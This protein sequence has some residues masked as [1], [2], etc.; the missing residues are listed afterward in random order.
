MLDFIYFSKQIQIFAVVFLFFTASL[1]A[2]LQSTVTGDAINQGNNCF[3]ITP[4]ELNQ[5]GGAW[6]S[7]PIDFDEDFT[8]YYQNNF[9]TKDGNG[10]DGMA[11]VFKSTSTPE[12]GN[13]G[14]GMG[15]EGIINS[16]II[17]F[18]TFLNGVN[19]DPFF[20][21]LAILRDGNPLH[22]GATALTPPVQASAANPNIEDGV[23][24]EV[25]IVWTAT[26]Q[27][28][29]VYFDC[30]LRES[31]TAN[32]KADVFNGDDTVFFG[33][34]GSTGGLSNLHQVCFNSISFVDDL[35]LQD[36]SI[37][38]G[39]FI[40][41]DATVPSGTSYSWSPTTGVGSPNSPITII[42]PTVTT[43]YAVTI[44]DNCG[45]SST[46]NI[47]ITINDQNPV[48][49]P[50]PNYNIGDAIPPLPTTSNNGVTGTWS[51]EIDNTETTTYT[52]TPDSGQC[53]S[54]Q[55]LT[56]FINSV[57]TDGDGVPDNIDIDDD[58][59]GI[60]DIN[61]LAFESVASAVFDPAIQQ[62][63]FSNISL[64]AGSIYQLTPTSFTLPQS[65]VNGGPFNGQT[66]QEIVIYDSFNDL[67]SDFNGNT[68]D[69]NNAYNGTFAGVDIPFAN[70]QASDYIT[71]LTYIGLVDTNGNG[72]YD[73]G[74]DEIIEP[75]FAVNEI[76]SFEPS[77][78]GDFYIVYTD[79]FYSDNLGELS[80]DTNVSSNLDTD[81]DG[82]F[83]RLD[84]DSDN[85]GIPDNVEAQTTLGYIP[86]SG[87]EAS[88]TDIDGD[89]LDDIYDQD[90][91][92]SSTETSIGLIPVNTDG[93]DNPDFTDEDSDN[94]GFPDIE[95]NGLADA[96]SIPFAD[97]DGD[98]LDNV[99]D[100]FNGFDVNNNIDNPETDLPDCNNNI[101][102][103]GDVDFREDLVLPS[104]LSI[105]PICEGGILEEL[106]VISTNGVSGT[107]SPA[108]NNTQTTTYTFTPD[109]VSCALETTL[110]IIVN[111]AITPIFDELPSICE[112]DNISPLPT[113]SNNGISGVW[114]P[115]LD[116]T[117][118]TTYTFT[119]NEDE[120]AITSTLVLTVNE[121][122][123]PIFDDIQPVCVGENI[124]PLPTTSNNGINGV[125]SPEL[126][127]TQ[128]TT[129]TFTPNEDECATSTT[130]EIEVN[131]VLSPVFNNIPAYCL[132]DNTPPLPIT[133]DNGINGTWSPALD[134][135]QTTFYTFT[136][137]EDECAEVITFEVDISEPEIVNPPQNLV[138]CGDFTGTQTFD[139]T[140]NDDATL[141][142]LTSTTFTYHNTLADALSG[143]NVILNPINYIP[144]D[145]QETIFIRIE[146]DTNASCF[147]TTS[148]SIERFD[149][150]ALTGN[151]LELCDDGSG[152]ETAIFDLT[153]NNSAILG[154]NQTT[155]SHNI[156]YHESPADADIGD[157]LIANPDVYQNLTSPQIIW[158]RVENQDN[159]DC[160]EVS[161]FQLLVT[162]S[163]P[164][165]TNISP[166]IACDDDNDGFFN[167]F[168]LTSKDNEI[169]FGNTDVSISYH[170][171]P[172]DAVNAVGALS[173]P[174]ANVVENTQTIYF[175]AVDTNN[176]CE[177]FG[178]FELQI[179]DSPL[180]IPITE[181]LV[182]CDEDNDGF[183][184]FDLT[185]VETEAL[186]NLDPL[187]LEITYHLSLADAQAGV[188]P[189]SEPDNYL[190]TNPTETIWIRVL[191]ISNPNGC[192]DVE[193]FDIIVEPTP[194]I[195]N[196]E[197]LAICDDEE[198]GDLS[199]EI[200]TFDLNDKIQEITQGNN[201]Y[202]VEFFESQ[203]D[204]DNNNPIAPIDSYVNIA[205]PQTLEIRVTSSTNACESFTTLTLVV[206]PVPSMAPE[207]DPIEI[208]DPDNDGFG[209]F[210]LDLAIVDILNNEPDVTITFH[211]TL[212]D[213]E[214]GVN[215][216]DTSQP[217]GSNNTNQQTLYVRAENTGPNGND[218]TGCF[219]TRPIDLIVVPSPEIDNLEDLTR[220][221]DE[222]PNGFASFDLTLNQDLALGNQNPDDVNITYHETQND[223]ELGIN[224]IA[225]PSNYT[226]ITNPQIIYVRI[227]DLTTGCY[228]LF[229]TTDDIN[230]TFT[231][232]VEPLPVVN[233]PAVLQVCDDD[234]N[235]D[236]FPQT[237]FDLTSTET[238]V[239]GVV[240]VPANLEYSYYESQEDFDNDNPIADP[241]AYVNIAQPQSILIKV[242]DTATENECFDATA[243][244]ISVLPLPSPSET[245]P[246]VLRLEAC[247]DEGNDG[248]AESPFDLTESGVLIAGSENVDLSF[249]L[250][251]DGAM[252]EDTDELIAD[253]TAYVNDP[254]LNLVDED[255]NP[256]STQVIYVR[257]DNATFGNFCFVVVPMEIVV[258]PAPVINPAGD[259]FAYTLCEDDSANPGQAMLFSTD[260]ITGNLWDITNGSADV[261]IP[262]LDPDAVPVQNIENFTVTYHLLEND[263]ESGVNPVAP[264]Y[265]ATDGEVLFIRI[266]NTG[267]SC[268][269]TRDIAE[270]QIVIE[271]RPAIALDD[272]DNL[273]AVCA[274]AIENPSS[275][276][277]DLTVQD[278]FV[279]PDTS[280]DTF[281]VYYAGMMN[282]NDG[283]V[284]EDPANFT[285]MQSPQTI[286]AEVVNAL[287]LCESSTFVS[288]D[289][290]VN[291][292]PLVDISEFD[293]AIVCIDSGN[294][295]INNDVSPPTIDTGLSDDDYSFVW[296]IDGA[297]NPSFTG[298][299][300]QA[301]IPGVYTVQV[302]DAVTG[303]SVV[304]NSAEVIQS[305]PPEFV[306]TALTPS[307][308]GTHVIEVSD[309]TGS[310][311]FEF[312]LDD[313][314]W[315]SLA[316]GQTT[317]VYT[318][319]APGQHT[320]RGRDNG[321]CGIIEK[322]IMLIDYPPF[323]TPNQ[324]G[325]NETWNITSLS[326]QPNAKIYI[327]DRY[328]KL[329]K[330]ITPAGEG[331]D[332]TYNGNIMP[333]Q[334]YW[335]KVEFT[336]PT[337][338]MPSIFKAH[339][340]LK[341]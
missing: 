164:V 92:S 94:D 224:P 36:E 131:P 214:L 275:G 193:A 327:L 247:D 109:D 277:F 279:N 76:I 51:P 117:Q 232:S 165:N 204:L 329:L 332:G 179:F 330:Q 40:T 324:D 97:T 55:T 61:E 307:F 119:P 21:H 82:I 159:P 12:I 144:S 241:T 20:D 229:D 202:F 28:L 151:N 60:L 156:T 132:G 98:G 113:T 150:E 30:V 338:M 83:D 39:D 133:S 169:H 297:V 4:D 121:I 242:V 177:Q 125:W 181:D 282:Y 77:V 143:E 96:I 137:N 186:G 206:D 310:G 286:I 66:L 261:I 116:N 325:I 306:L 154:P 162:D 317:I 174:Y 41:V 328:G 126:D 63:Q 335:F 314:P 91:N 285:T 336:E 255:G 129:Y 248:I 287:T 10:A 183:L 231:L 187:N 86:P 305:S 266:T 182:G 111:T 53:A 301:T 230:N 293:G 220:C 201:E 216:I 70:L 167:N 197:P 215:P 24:H 281:V 258:Y 274:D 300:I 320:V 102:T 87:T 207:L 256:T 295:V 219:D 252:S 259:P 284:I 160:F 180:L 79:S 26:T 88:I 226:N 9:G 135:T 105:D 291:P 104:F 228:D 257:V 190:N 7:N 89:G 73:N 46:D 292:L 130:L 106:P 333:S 153:Q 138:E 127:N 34:V 245:D 93:T 124:D 45:N 155:A 278:E 173:S 221:D 22:N 331:W 210:D 11:L 128:T 264:G 27:T 33:F 148:F 302:T 322:S 212:A 118:T 57:D 238:E 208:C 244:T 211:L 243:L 236:P 2:Q 276:T 110:E 288:F 184:F 265:L 294:N 14:G 309:I 35:Q 166:L 251:E 99:F 195:V 107:W 280:G 18:D 199:D 303:C 72:N 262:L 323:F 37:C 108:L 158:V 240:A 308:S 272:P 71:Q 84:L 192:F 319:L 198:S 203:S 312:Q 50:Y 42:S 311:D 237:V 15:Y 19:G 47:T 8:I 171:T 316:P 196:P 263:A 217:F 234:Y 146:D 283:V 112:G 270:V 136:P 16:L 120:C 90:T 239:A 101:L 78:S 172:S 250:S 85:D 69:S 298:A 273:P 29:E 191:D 227:E 268:F 134:I 296:S 222:S 95:E 337:T 175:L 75:I 44:L 157:N 6:F 103:G 218:G 115:A 62:W 254:S 5:A 209:E 141:G 253:P 163:A 100:V 3:I 52:F 25:R 80:F 1:Y 17:E 58:N 145:A 271:P 205:N 49:D 194:N 339:F 67:W 260:D 235:F 56:I 178:S 200:A 32:I 176:G 299:S 65:T 304:S 68:Y 38:S 74:I 139:L 122:T 147:T 64:Q 152:T 168:D 334:D 223:A 170:L 114:S 142:I 140:Q 290:F 249:Y 48:F 313:G 326:D 149:A 341:R 43:T 340:T 318:G 23:D 233:T 31:L 189:V 213:A 188:N 161:N 54:V 225:V 321:G 269:N 185:Q 13:V 315:E 289:V 81:N 267:T 59:D 123:T 246:D